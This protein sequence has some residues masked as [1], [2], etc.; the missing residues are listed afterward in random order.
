MDVGTRVDYFRKEH[1]D[2][3]GLLDDWDLAVELT[4]D[5]DERESLRGLN[6]LRELQPQLEALHAHC[7]SEERNVEGPYRAYLEKGQIDTLRAEHEQL[8]RLLVDL[9]TE[10]RFATIYQTERARLAGRQ[11]ATLARKHI[12]FEEKLLEQVEKKL[13]EEAEEKLLLRYTQ[14]PD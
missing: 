2:F 9:F 7:T 10:L 5:K 1:H 6:R 13:A 14:S 8:S 3:L 12:L 11:V 4:A